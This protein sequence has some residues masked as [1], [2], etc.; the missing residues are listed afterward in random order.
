MTNQ[1]SKIFQ[2]DTAIRSI[3]EYGVDLE[4]GEI[5]EQ[6]FIALAALEMSKAE[7]T[8]NVICYYKES[9][10]MVGVI[11]SEIKR[12][13][14]LKKKLVNQSDSIERYVEKITPAGEKVVTP[15]YTISWRKSESIEV[16]PN[17]D[18]EML[19]LLYPESVRIKKEIDKTAIK[20][21]VKE[22]GVC[23]AGVALITKNNMS[24]K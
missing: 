14:D 4:T 17:I 19:A 2:V 5:S 3:L 10:G 16:S 9:N 21:L 11:D 6:S 13:Q 1:L 18:I 15:E 7:L 12:L 8:K 23:I 22:S 20:K 24:I